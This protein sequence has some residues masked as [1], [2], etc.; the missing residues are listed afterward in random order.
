MARPRRGAGGSQR[1]RN[2]ERW[3]ARPRGRSQM[4]WEP[5]RPL[6]AHMDGLEA[7]PQIRAREPDAAIVVQSG[8]SARAYARD[9]DGAGSGR[10]RREG[11]FAGRAAPGQAASGRAA[12]GAKGWLKASSVAGHPGL[13]PGVA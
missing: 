6:D 1:V 10:L 5:P 2:R 12:P 8:F 9:R 7:I 3:G 11:K 13:E 4:T